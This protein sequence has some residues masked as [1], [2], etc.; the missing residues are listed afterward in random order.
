MSVTSARRIDRL[1]AV[2]GVPLLAHDLGDFQIVND[3]VD[4]LL[5]RRCPRMATR[6][7]STPC[8][9]FEN[10]RRSLLTKDATDRAHLPQNSRG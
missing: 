7:D 10:T 2:E 8:P 3:L 5:R 1:A 4:V 9:Q 6:V